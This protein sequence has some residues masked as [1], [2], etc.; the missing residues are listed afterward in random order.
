MEINTLVLSGG[1]LKGFAFLGVL[2]ALSERKLLQDI[3]TY[4]G[5]SIGALLATLLTAGW[6]Y[7]ELI[8]FV[9]ET[10]FSELQ[11]PELPKLLIHYGL[12]SGLKITA[13]LGKMLKEKLDA[14][15]CQLTL[16]KLHELTNKNLKIVTTCLEDQSTVCLDHTT[17]PNLNIIHAVRMSMSIPLFFTAVKWNNKTYVDGGLLN[18]FPIDFADDPEKTLGALVVFKHSGD[19]VMSFQEFLASVFGCLFKFAASVNKAKLP[20]K[21][22]FIESNCNG[23]DFK[24]DKITK[25]CLI[26][27]GYSESVKFLESRIKTPDSVEEVDKES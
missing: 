25:Q 11:E 16:K 13:L 24:M 19:G 22:I 20:E 15:I 23:I 21:T 18:H 9:L 26:N 4:I 1:A 12:D 8:E 5:C 14:P 6:T 7:E 2:K 3:N 10:D 27:I 17:F